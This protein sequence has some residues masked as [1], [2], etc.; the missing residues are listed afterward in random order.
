MI[1]EK[2]ILFLFFLFYTQI[3]KAADDRLIIEN[4]NPC[5]INEK[6]VIYSLSQQFNGIHRLLRLLA[7]IIHEAQTNQAMSHEHQEENI[8]E[9]LEKVI[10][11]I[12]MPNQEI[13]VEKMEALIIK[14]EDLKKK[15]LYLCNIGTHSSINPTPH[16]FI[17]IALHVSAYIVSLFVILI[18]Q[19]S[20]EITNE[21]YATLHVIEKFNAIFEYAIEKNILHENPLK[22]TLEIEVRTN[23]SLIENNENI[24]ESEES[25]ENK[26]RPQGCC[27]I[28]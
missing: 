20:F 28:T 25:E 6:M 8:Q 3:T 5:I 26:E 13:S 17:N 21:T 4:K 7:D 14:C 2:K 12:C 16:F 23:E 15:L 27:T 11:A 1:K 24:N 18:T 10:Y 9:Q 19:E 22:S